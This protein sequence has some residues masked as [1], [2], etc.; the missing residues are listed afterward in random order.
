MYILLPAIGLPKLD[1]ASITGG[2]VGA[3]GKFAKPVG[4]LVFLMGGIAWGYLYARFWHWHSPAG[5][6]G[7]SLIP[8]VI[9]SL[10]VLP[11]L[12]RFQA[13]SMPGFI[14]LRVGGPTAMVVNLLEH[15]VFGLVLGFLY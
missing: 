14:W 8:F 7:Y 4:I 12:N 9:S 15:L 2:W 11:Q 10:T 3:A 1:F 6:M 13:L 5:G